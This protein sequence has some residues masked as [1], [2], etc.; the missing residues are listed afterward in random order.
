MEQI[1]PFGEQYLEIT[2]EKELMPDEV[3]SGRVVIPPIVEAR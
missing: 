2:N 3:V 1:L